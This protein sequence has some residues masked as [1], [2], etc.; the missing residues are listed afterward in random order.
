MTK[1]YMK[2]NL[3]IAAA[4]IPKVLLQNLLPKHQKHFSEKRQEKLLA[5][6]S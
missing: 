4:S 1:Q 2:I 6:E 3:F 5:I